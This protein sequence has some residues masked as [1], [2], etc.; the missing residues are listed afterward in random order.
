MCR[1]DAL[2]KH[3]TLIPMIQ[4]YADL[5]LVAYLTNLA[6]SRV[7]WNKVVFMVSTS[8]G[9]NQKLRCIL[10]TIPVGSVHSVPALGCWTATLKVWYYRTVR[11]KSHVSM[12]QFKLYCMLCKLW[13][14]HH[15]NISAHK[16]KRWH[17]FML[18]RLPKT[19]QRQIK[20]ECSRSRVI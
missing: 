17:S 5:S 18:Q 13:S 16:I 14:K 15:I 12:T 3:W 9:W 2:V 10:L 19:Q 11:R 7:C 4:D 20:S 8:G 6:Q 1:L